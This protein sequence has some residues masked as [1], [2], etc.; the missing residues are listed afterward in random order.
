MAQNPVHE[1]LK[2]ILEMYE[3]PGCAYCFR[4]NYL[5]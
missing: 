2:V 3:F 1:N 5:T 4:L